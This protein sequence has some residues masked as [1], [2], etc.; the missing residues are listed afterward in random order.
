MVTSARAN[1]CRDQPTRLQTRLPRENR[2]ARLAR[3]ELD[4]VAGAVGRPF[5]SR[6]CRGGWR[7]DLLDVVANRFKSCRLQPPLFS[8][9]SKIMH[10]RPAS[11]SPSRVS[12]STASWQQRGFGLASGMLPLR[13]SL[14]TAQPAADVLALGARLSWP[15]LRAAAQVVVVADH[16]VLTR[17]RSHADELVRHARHRG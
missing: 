3:A 16:V 11:V 6:T 14:E 12:L 7:R 15:C 13:V 10:G 5:H 17:P 2:K 9:N 1:F 4:R 8:S